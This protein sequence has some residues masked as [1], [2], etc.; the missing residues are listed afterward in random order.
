MGGPIRP[1]FKSHPPLQPT[2]TLTPPEG[3]TP[4]TSSGPAH[5]M[6]LTRLF[7]EKAKIK[8][9]TI[10]M[11]PLIPEPDSSPPFAGPEP[12]PPDSSVQ[13]TVND[14]EIVES[15]EV[16]LNVEELRQRFNQP[17]DS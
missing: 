14:E 10:E 15:E 8:P 4:N 9:T 3:D 16:I 7:G 13:I 5:I 17:L 6:E 12:E 11:T 2:P 1:R